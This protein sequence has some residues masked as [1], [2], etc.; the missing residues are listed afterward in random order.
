MLYFPPPQK[1]ILNTTGKGKVWKKT[2]HV[3]IDFFL[4]KSKSGNIIINKVDLRVNKITS[5]FSKS[6]R[7]TT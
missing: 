2:Y 7:D 1:F 6:K 4:K 3:N 5:N